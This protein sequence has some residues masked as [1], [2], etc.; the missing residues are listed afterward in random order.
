MQNWSRGGGI[1]NRCLLN[2]PAV[3]GLEQ[4]DLDDEGLTELRRSKSIQSNTRTR[5]GLVSAER[6]GNESL[7]TLLEVESFKMDTRQLVVY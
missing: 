7:T 2:E 3:R 4:S 1:C 6:I 5:A